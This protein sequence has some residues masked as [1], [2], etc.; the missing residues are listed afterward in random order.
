MVEKLL[1]N[2]SMAALRLAWL[3]PKHGHGFLSSKH[4]RPGGVFKAAKLLVVGEGVSMGAIPVKL[5]VTVIM[6]AAAWAA[7]PPRSRRSFM[8]VLSLGDV[9]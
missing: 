6:S 2:Q 1:Q 9:G 5:V 8:L 3:T 4:L 7:R